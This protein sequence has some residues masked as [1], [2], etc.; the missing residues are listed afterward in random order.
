MLFKWFEVA[1]MMKK[2]MTFDQTKGRY[3]AIDR[4]ANCTTARSKESI[5]LCRCDRQ[6]LAPGAEYLKLRQLAPDASKCRIAVNSLQ[7]L[8]QDEIGQSKSLLIEFSI[9]P[10]RMRIRGSREVIDPDGRIH[11]CH[12]GCLV[13][14]PALARL[15]QISVPLHLAAKLP[16][17]CLRMGFY[18][19]PQSRLHDCLFCARAGTAHRLLHQ[20]VID[21]NVCPHGT[22]NV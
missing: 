13:S 9:E 5:V 14:N 16:D 10:L 18:Q 3:Q 20:L 15:V 4:L 11:D 22:P 8:A 1:V 21:L 7:D 2:G 19:Q 6:I 12:T 17:A